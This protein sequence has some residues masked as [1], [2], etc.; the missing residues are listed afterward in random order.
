MSGGKTTHDSLKKRVNE[1]V[2]RRERRKGSVEIQRIAEYRKQRSPITEI[3]HGR[4]PKLD[5]QEG[6][7]PIANKGAQYTFSTPHGEIKKVYSGKGRFQVF[8]NG[9]RK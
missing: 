6:M 3:Y 7:R 8:H 9:L 2:S 1:E 4:M 5:V